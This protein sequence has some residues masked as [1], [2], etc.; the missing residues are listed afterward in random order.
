MKK[1]II[2]SFALSLLLMPMFV[3]AS[4]KY[5]TS[6]LKETLEEEEIEVA[7]SDYEETDEQAVIYL[8]RGHGCGYCHS[9]LEYL[10]SIT[11][12]YGKYFKLVSY[13]VWYNEDNAN[14]MSDVA[15][16][17]G[18]QASGVPFIVIG[19][20]VFPGYTESYNDS[21]LAAI[22]ETYR[23]NN[24]YDVLNELEKSIIKDKIVNVITKVIPVISI[25]LVVVSFVYLNNKDKVLT[26]R[27]NELEK[28]V[29]LLNKE[30]KMLKKTTT[31]SNNTKSKKSTSN[32]TKKED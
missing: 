13:E 1:K 29:L 32:K 27:V 6:N 12:E 8:F 31:K 25:I 26:A 22:K 11:D 9:F 30:K 4:T 10:N 7:F 14:L 2:F 21:I 20:Q 18:E 19:D 3:S 5:E 15:T 28:T 16:F 24:E 23:N 17:L